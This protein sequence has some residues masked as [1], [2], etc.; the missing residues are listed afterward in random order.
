M[1]EIKLPLGHDILQGT[2]LRGLLQLAQIFRQEVGR[3]LPAD[4]NRELELKR[5][6]GECG[7]TRE[8]K[9]CAH[10]GISLLVLGMAL[11]WRAWAAGL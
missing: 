3:R 7:Q 4:G 5:L 9:D 10:Y 6:L 11:S 2:T 1:R 8:A